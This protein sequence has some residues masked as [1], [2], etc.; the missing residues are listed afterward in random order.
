MRTGG[1]LTI[2][3]ALLVSLAQGGG[4]S[5]FV[6]AFIGWMVFDQINDAA[7]CDA[8][9]QCCTK[10]GGTVTV[11]DDNGNPLGTCNNCGPTPC[12]S[13]DNTCWSCAAVD[14]KW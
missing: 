12:I 6:C 5:V 7:V 9:D 1:C 8:N 2:E 11:L 14:G 10:G 4:C 3:I 13:T